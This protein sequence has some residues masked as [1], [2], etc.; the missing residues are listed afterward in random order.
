MNNPSNCKADKK[1]KG[2]QEIMFFDWKIQLEKKNNSHEIYEKKY[3]LHAR[4]KKFHEKYFIESITYHQ[5]NPS[6]K[7]S[8][9]F[10][11]IQDIQK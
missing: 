10:K 3:N 1:N 11:N 8:T 7:Q 6:H 4:M 9:D 2:Y 5:V